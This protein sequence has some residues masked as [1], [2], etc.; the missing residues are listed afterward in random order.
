MEYISATEYSKLSGFSR[1]YILKCL[2]DRKKESLSGVKHAKKVGATWVIS[3]HIG[4][5]IH[6]DR[7]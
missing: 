3:C 6:K 7:R 1:A 5:V 4:E 2:K